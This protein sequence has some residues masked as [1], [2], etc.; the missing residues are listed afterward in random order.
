MIAEL[1]PFIVKILL[2]IGAIFGFIGGLGILRMPDVYNRIHAETIC[3][4]GG[5]IVILIGVI[6]YR[7]ISLFSLKAL[8]IALFLFLTNPVSSHAIARAAHKSSEV[9]I[10][11]GT[12][13]DA[14]EEGEK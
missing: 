5:A 4:V 3:C 6:V 7:G 1:L 2:I 10:W 13:G 8:V 14:L 9:E 11:P 12:V